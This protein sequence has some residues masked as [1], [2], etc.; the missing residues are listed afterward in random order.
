MKPALLVIDVQK[1]FFATSPETARSLDSA[2]PVINNAIAQFR[3]SQLPVICIQHINEAAGVTP[4]SPGFALPENL[5][6][7]AADPHFFKTYGN[8]FNKTD[9][10]QYL[11]S[12]NVDTLILTGYC[13]EYCVLSTYRGALDR[14]FAPLLLRGG[15]ASRN[16]GNIPFVENINEVLSPGA[17]KLLLQTC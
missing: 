6:I 10:E 8:A 12:Q 9:L 4:D 13:A 15:L 11:R 3:A 5:A 16:P 2:I 14:D 17:L 1:A 7:E